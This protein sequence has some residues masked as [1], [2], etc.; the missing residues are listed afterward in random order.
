LPADSAWFWNPPERP[1]HGRGRRFESAHLHRSE[2]YSGPGPRITHIE[3]FPAGATNPTSTIDYGFDLD[4]NLTDR[5]ESGPTW[6]TI[7][8]KYDDLNRL[9]SETPPNGGTPN[10]EYTYDQEG[11]LKTV[12]DNGETTTYYYDSVNMVTTLSDPEGVRFPPPL[13]S[14]KNFNSVPDRRAGGSSGSSTGRPAGSTNRSRPSW[15]GSKHSTRAGPEREPGA[16]SEWDG[17]IVRKNSSVDCLRKARR[18]EPHTEDPQVAP[19]RILPGEPQDQTTP[20]ADRAGDAR[21]QPGNSFHLRGSRCHW[22]RVSVTRNACHR[23]LGKI[24]LT[25]A[26]IIRSRLRNVS[27]RTCLERTL[28]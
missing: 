18:A 11:N 24:R 13:P 16:Q 7:N 4:G 14:T 10:L 1:S 12:K 6:G 23:S 20:S 8:F 15:L 26:G 9:I 28:S 25:A 19:P 27:R 22:S 21:A 3:Y 2:A 5:H 17:R